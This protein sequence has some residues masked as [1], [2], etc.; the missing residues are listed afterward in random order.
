MSKPLVSIIIPAY[1][2]G[3]LITE[4][5]GSAL[6]QTYKNTEIIVVDDGSTEDVGAILAPL[7]RDKKI[8]Y[9]RQ[10]NAGQAA[11]RK[12]GFEISKGEFVSFVDAD[13]LIAPEKIELQTDYLLKNPDCGVCYS[14]I[15]HFWDDRRDVLLRKK[16]NYHSGYIFDKL[17]RENFIQVMT[18]LVRREILEKYGLPG[19]EFRRS[20]DWYLWLNLSY[21][22]VKFC[23]MDKILSFQRRQRRG[24]LSDQKSYFKET[25]ETNISIY[26]K[27]SGILSR[28]ET[29]K[30]G[31]DSLINFWRFRLALGYVILGD[32]ANALRALAQFRVHGVPD[33]LKKIGLRKMLFILPVKWLG[34]IIFDLRE[35]KRYKS[36]VEFE[37]KSIRLPV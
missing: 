3:R 22:G 35:R 36:F 7:I 37:D 9:F 14:D 32:K 8:I 25:A 17:I 12:K 29:E 6:G 11:A 19:A 5:I 24:T 18:A 27:F 30:H 34:K 4:T 28:A 16:L 10:N 20:D 23:F 13:D 2:P 33:F 31:L 15:L 26:E 1:N 21:H